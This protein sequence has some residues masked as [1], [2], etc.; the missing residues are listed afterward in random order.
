NQIFIKRRLEISVNNLES[1]CQ[2]ID[3]E[4][5][6]LTNDIKESQHNKQQ[7]ETLLQKAN[8]QVAEQGNLFIHRTLRD[9]N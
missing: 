9:E 8:V 3:V 4:R 6:K 2:L 7:L 5:I 1:N